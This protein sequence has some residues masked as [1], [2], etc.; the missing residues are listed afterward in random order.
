MLLVLIRFSFQSYN[1]IPISFVNTYYLHRTGQNTPL[2]SIQ[3]FPKGLRMFAGDQY[4]TSYNKTD[5]GSMAVSYVCLDYQGGSS[6]D[7]QQFPDHNCK[8]GLRTQLHF[9]SCWNGEDKDSPDHKSHMSYPVGSA[10]GGDCPT[11]HPH[12]LMNLFYEF[13]YDVGSFDFRAGQTNWVFAN[14]DTTGLA[15]H[16]DFINGWDVNTLTNAVKQCTDM[17]FDPQLES[18]FHLSQCLRTTNIHCSFLFFS[19]SLF[20]DCGPL[21]ASI[22]RKK[23]QSCTIPRV[24]EED[25]DGPLKALPGCNPVS[26]GPVAKASTCANQIVPAIKGLSPAHTLAAGATT[27]AAATPSSVPA[28]Q[29]STH[30]ASSSSVGAS[31]ASTSKA[32]SSAVGAPTT[33]PLSS[34][35]SGPTSAPAASSSSSSHPAN[36]PPPPAT[37][38]PA[39]PASSSSAAPPAQSSHHTFSFPNGHHHFDQHGSSTHVNVALPTQ[40]PDVKQCKRSEDSPSKERAEEAFESRRSAFSKHRRHAKR[41]SGQH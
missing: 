32:S 36:P 41:L 29:Q 35:S 2:A 20:V 16:G 15:M 10:E 3:P 11:T 12:K 37:P 27:S 18:T 24:V 39:P 13:V 4:R 9:P 30:V 7:L 5:P 25:I 8:D 21:A 22:D 19:L 6:G 40:S 17:F 33:V 38:S 34:A 1:R 14:G 26:G 31:S 28:Q 23:S